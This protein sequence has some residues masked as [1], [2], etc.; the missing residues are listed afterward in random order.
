MHPPT[1]TH[2]GARRT[3]AAGWRYDDT[4][5]GCHRQVQE[6]SRVEE[7]KPADILVWAFSRQNAEKINL[8]CFSHPACGILL[9]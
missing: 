7:T 9:W 3:H 6:S 4:G 2:G 1:H 8:C 5:E